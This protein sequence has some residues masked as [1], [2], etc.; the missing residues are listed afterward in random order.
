MYIFSLRQNVTTLSLIPHQLATMTSTSICNTNYNFINESEWAF[1]A[2]WRWLSMSKSTFMCGALPVPKTARMLN[3]IKQ[4]LFGSH[5]I[6]T[7]YPWVLYTLSRSRKRQLLSPKASTEATM[8]RK[9]RLLEGS[10]LMPPPAATVAGWCRWLQSQ[11]QISQRQ[12][13]LW[14]VMEQQNPRREIIMN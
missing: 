5:H 10:H 7:N 2:Q 3:P 11:I 13:N 6:I 9:N 8:A 12:E 14:K 1:S 4:A